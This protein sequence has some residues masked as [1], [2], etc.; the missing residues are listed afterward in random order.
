MLGIRGERMGEKDR[1][2]GRP[3][4]QKVIWTVTHSVVE[5]GRSKGI[6]DLDIS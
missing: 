1:S 5:W 2:E 6:L 4:G 3:N